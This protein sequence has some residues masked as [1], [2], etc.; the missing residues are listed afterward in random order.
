MVRKELGFPK[1]IS[2]Q[3]YKY[4]QLHSRENHL[5]F[6]FLQYYEQKKKTNLAIHE[7]GG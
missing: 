2:F 1:L 6:F 3:K 7:E 5:S 4:K